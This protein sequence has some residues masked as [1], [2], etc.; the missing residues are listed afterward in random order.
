MTYGWPNR[1]PS[2]S[3][4]TGCLTHRQAPDTQWMLRVLA[5]F[6]IVV[7]TTGSQ[8][9]SGGA[10][11][12]P[13]TVWRQDPFILTA[14]LSVLKLTVSSAAG[15]HVRPPWCCFSTRTCHVRYQHLHHQTTF[16][17]LTGIRRHSRS[18]SCYPGLCLRHLQTG[19]LNSTLLGPSSTK[20]TC[21]RTHRY[22]SISQK[23][24]QVIN[25]QPDDSELDSNTGKHN[26]K[27]LSRPN[28]TKQVFKSVHINLGSF[29][30]KTISLTLIYTESL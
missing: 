4:E 9:W 11:S 30:L 14:P 12:E 1:S 7:I 6:I 18:W 19:G 28:G 27:G 20:G 13:R 15:V 3:W 17:T 22:R 23:S 21:M 25:R 2:W 24:R 26:F 29:S 8:P 16:T 10:E 5:A